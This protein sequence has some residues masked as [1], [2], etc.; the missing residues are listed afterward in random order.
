MGHD[1]EGIFVFDCRFDWRQF[2]L[3]S[4]LNY[5][6]RRG[7]LGTIGSLAGPACFLPKLAVD[8][9]CGHLLSASLRDHTPP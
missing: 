7:A 1:E 8:G 3:I 2:P 4:H 6:V 9:A 5:H